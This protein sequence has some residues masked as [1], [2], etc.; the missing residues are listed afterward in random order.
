MD[1]QGSSWRYEKCGAR[2]GQP[3]RRQGEGDFRG[4]PD[5]S[6]VTMPTTPVIMVTTEGEMSA[7]TIAVSCDV[8]SLLFFLAALF[9]RS[10]LFPRFCGK[11]FFFHFG[12]FFYNYYTD[13][14][15][16]AVAYLTLYWC[17]VSS[18]ILYTYYFFRYHLFI[19]INY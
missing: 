13:H 1:G 5:T 14:I 10:L 3:R 19:R 2:S 6:S 18:F 16:S 11:S 4:T 7:E 12:Q 8:V 17:S 9:Y 15:V